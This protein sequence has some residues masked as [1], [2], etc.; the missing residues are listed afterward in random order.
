MRELSFSK[1]SGCGNDFLLIDN[2]DLS[3]PSSA[4]KLIQRLCHHPEGVG[5]DGIVLLETS[6]VADFKMRI[7]NADG[8]EAEM[9]GNGLRCLKQ[10]I[11][12]QGIFTSPLSIET[13][14]RILQV[15]MHQD[16]VKASMGTPS[17]M[18]LGIN[19][20]VESTNYVVHYVDTGVPHL[21]HFVD[22]IENVEVL[23]LGPKLRFHPLFSPKGAN[24]NFAQ[25][26]GPSSLRLRTY[27]RGVE[28][29]TLA[30]GTGATAAAIISSVIHQLT[31]PI[32][33][34]TRSRQ[35]LTIDFSIDG[36]HQITN[37]TQ[38]G[39]ATYHFKGSFALSKEDLCQQN[40]S[41]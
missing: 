25:I 28:R 39:P 7:F 9:C 27:E 2:R 6:Q 15:E 24:A 32:T 22:D 14:Q 33:V 35:S 12:E 13:M 41:K 30:C 20:L 3:F 10:F 37:V 4:S 29:E 17:S 18:K 21:I 5:A 1:Y 40:Q 23:S 36:K 26:T 16:L 8:S 34:E 31:A 38:S 11:Q 19:L